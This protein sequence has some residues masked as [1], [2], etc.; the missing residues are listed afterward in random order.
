M[1]KGISVDTEVQR[2][3]QEEWMFMWTT[4]SGVLE[5]AGIV[6]WHHSARLNILVEYLYWAYQ[7]TLQFEVIFL[8]I[9][10]K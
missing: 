5:L 3:I 4:S 1:Q 9:F 6:E 2:N 10:Q 8:L 7:E